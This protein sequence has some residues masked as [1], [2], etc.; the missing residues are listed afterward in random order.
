MC[1]FLPNLPRFEP[2]RVAYTANGEFR[3]DF[4]PAIFRSRVA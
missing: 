1:H 4:S 2:F 3:Y